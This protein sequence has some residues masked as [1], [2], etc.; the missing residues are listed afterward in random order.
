MVLSLLV[1][2]FP[3]CLGEVHESWVCFPLKITTCHVSCVTSIFVADMFPH[4]T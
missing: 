4:V 2:G 1:K 3:G